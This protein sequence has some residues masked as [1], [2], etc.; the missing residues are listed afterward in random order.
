[1]VSL[2]ELV[3]LGRRYLKAKAEEDA[4]ERV[5]MQYTARRMRIEEEDLPELML[6]ARAKSFALEDGTTISV[7]PDVYVSISE[8]RKPVVF[9]WLRKNNY[10]GLIKTV[11]SVEFVR[12]QEKE[13]AKLHDAL[14]KK[15]YAAEI[16]EAV[17][18]QTMKAFVNEQLREGKNIPLELFGARPVTKAQAK[19]PTTKKRGTQ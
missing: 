9:D 15:G 11:V 16:T 1:M 4:A 13:A 19:F 10:G 7:K 14:S 2:S 8:E 3:E 18:A 17:H 5:R 6:E 12:G